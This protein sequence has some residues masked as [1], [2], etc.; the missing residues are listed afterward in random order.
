MENNNSFKRKIKNKIKADAILSADWHIRPD[1]PVCR[2]DDFFK[3]MSDKIDFILALS[4]EENCPVLIAGDLGNHALNNGW[5]TWLSQWAINKFKG[6][7]IIAILGQHDLP[8]HRLDLFGKSGVGILHAAGVINV[9]FKPVVVKNT[10]NIFPFSY[11]EPILSHE[12]TGMPNIAMIHQMV[13]EN[14]SLY[15][16]QIAPKGNALLKKHP[17]FSII[18]SGDNHNPFVAEYEGRALVNPGS[19]TRST[20]DQV[21]H[22]PRVYK[23][24]A[25]SNTIEA[26]F[27]PIQKNVINREHIK[28]TKENDMRMEAYIA[29][30]KKDVEI[31]LSFEKNMEAYLNKYRIKTNVKN[32]VFEAMEAK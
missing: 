30:I 26:V 4:K 10:F 29:R 23:W 7:N 32:K 2:T 1:V 28:L 24:Y 9:I 5:P 16:G 25:E 22:T 27:L 13:V 18:L 6:H 3:A 31:Q 15:P 20:A 17:E 11:G 21:E 12:S 19:I 14:K 8:N